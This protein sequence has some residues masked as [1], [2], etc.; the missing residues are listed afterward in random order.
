MTPFELIGREA[1]PEEAMR[2]NQSRAKPNK[3]DLSIE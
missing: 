2:N 1:S 3:M